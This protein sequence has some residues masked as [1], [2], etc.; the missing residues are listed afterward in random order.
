MTYTV[1][2]TPAAR[3]Q[4]RKLDPPIQRRIATRIDALAEDPRPDGVVKLSAVEPPLYRIREGDWRILYRIEDEVLLVLV[5][6]I[7][8]RS[9]VYAR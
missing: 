3:R 4:L 6:R 9:E 7:G 5:V 1:E 2:L 8:H